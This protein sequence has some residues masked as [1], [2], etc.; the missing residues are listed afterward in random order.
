M[1]AHQQGERSEAWARTIPAPAGCV[2]V[3]RSGTAGAVRGAQEPSRESLRLASLLAPDQQ[4]ASRGDGPFDLAAAAECLCLLKEAFIVALHDD[5]VADIV[6]C[7][8]SALGA[9]DPDAS[10]CAYSRLTV[11]CDRRARRAMPRARSA[12]VR[13]RQQPSRARWTAS[14]R[15][16]AAWARARPWSMRARRPCGAPRR[17]PRGRWPPSTPTAPTCTESMRRFA[18]AT[19]PFGLSSHV[20]P[21]WDA[22]RCDARRHTMPRPRQPHGSE[23]GEAHT[24]SPRATSRST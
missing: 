11:E 8:A 10:V 9:H 19:R 16:I 7:A 6:S 14:M 24:S 15:S 18:R 21:S 20:S 1:R 5:I 12:Y 2:G 3:D 17:A 13:L 4:R 22:L 23:H